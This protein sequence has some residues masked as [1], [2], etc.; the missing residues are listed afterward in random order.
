[1]V[2][3]MGLNGFVLKNKEIVSCVSPPL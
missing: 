1:L 2:K 3:C